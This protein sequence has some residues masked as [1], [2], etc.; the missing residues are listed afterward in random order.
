[1][2]CQNDA[3][4]LTVL[5]DY[6]PRKPPRKGVHATVTVVKHKA[7]DVEYDM[8]IDLE[9]W[10]ATHVPCRLIKKAEEQLLRREC[11]DL[12]MRTTAISLLTRPWIHRLSTQEKAASIASVSATGVEKQSAVASAQHSQN[13]I[14][15][16]SFLFIPPLK[17]VEK[18]LLFSSKATSRIAWSMPASAS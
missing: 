1:M 10:R 6:I 11:E 3:P 4:V 17:L 12:E 13:A 16:E 14:A 15:T 8:H 7:Q 9:H 5:P 18:V 2:S